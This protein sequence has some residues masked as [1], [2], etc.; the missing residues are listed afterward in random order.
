MLVSCRDRTRTGYTIMG[1]DI[2][3]NLVLTLAE[4]FMEE[5][6]NVSLAVSGGGSGTGIAALINQRTDI[7]N[8]SRPLKEV[9]LSLARESGIEPVSFVFATDGFAIIVHQSNPIT[10]LTLQ[11]IGRLFHG[12]YQNWNEVGGP[13]REITLYGR[14]S[15]S[16]TYIYF[17][18]QVV[19]ADYAT[20]VR[21]MNGTAQI[22][23]AV[24]HDRSA[25][26]YVGIGYIHRQDG[27]VLPGLRVIPVAP[28]S[29]AE[30]VSP[31]E[32]GVIT[33]GR[34]PLS[35]PLFQYFESVPRD[36][37]RKFLEFELSEEGQ[38]II[39]REGCLS[40]RNC[41]GPYP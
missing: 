2:E 40:F 30:A 21:R 5:H 29:E 15:N 37:L 9:E 16:G 27:S 38:A 35:R 36:L 34:Y 14:Q 13:D 32:K 8:S 3:V 31:L 6:E 4:A 41:P 25:V 24:R 22:V 18:D 11:Q 39:Q 20:R 19:K 23:E 12:E 26:G 7:A 33:S 1:S 28:A 17:R 10:Q